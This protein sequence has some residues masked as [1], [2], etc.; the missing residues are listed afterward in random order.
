MSG[1]ET[2]VYGLDDV[3]KSNA[4]FIDIV[5]LLQGRT[6]TYQDVELFALAILAKDKAAATP[7]LR[8]GLI[9]V[10]FD[11]RNHAIDRFRNW[12]TLAGLKENQLHVLSATAKVKTG[13]R[14]DMEN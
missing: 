6:G 13:S 1:V 11:R 8:R 5:F 7:D 12:E 14:A 4:H 2:Y 3:R 9:V 10:S